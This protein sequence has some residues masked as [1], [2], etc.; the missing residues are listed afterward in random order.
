MAE[1]MQVPIR[2]AK[3]RFD[4]ALMVWVVGAAAH[5]PFSLMFFQKDGCWDSNAHPKNGRE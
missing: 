1:A 3:K 2:K 5:Q 4:P